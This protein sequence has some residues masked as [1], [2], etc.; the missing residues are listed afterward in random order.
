MNGEPIDADFSPDWGPRIRELREAK[1]ISGRELAK[2]IGCSAE[3]LSN[4][5]LGR[6]TITREFLAKVAQVLAPPI[7]IH[8]RKK[9]ESFDWKYYGS[10]R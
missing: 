1:D 5:E 2:L 4:V 7:V 9:P 3:Y 10:M 8:K 6:E